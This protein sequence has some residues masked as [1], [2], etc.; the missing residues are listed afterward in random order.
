MG[1][2]KISHSALG[3]KHP[4]YDIAA[5]KHFFL[6]VLANSIIEVALLDGARSM[7]VT[8]LFVLQVPLTPIACLHP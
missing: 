5:L 8:L 2:M 3:T 7:P 4:L 1:T 6:V